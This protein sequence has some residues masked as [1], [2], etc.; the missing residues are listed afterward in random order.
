M[1]AAAAE[2]LADDEETGKVSAIA[3]DED[4]EDEEPAETGTR[5]VRRASS[6]FY[7]VLEAE[8]RRKTEAE[9]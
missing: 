7:A 4:S 6:R 9:D 8:R 3:D 5:R 2:A 1:E